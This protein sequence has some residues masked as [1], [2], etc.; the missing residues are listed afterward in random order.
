MFVFAQLNKA[1]L[2]KSRCLCLKIKGYEFHI[3]HTTFCVRGNVTIESL[4]LLTVDEFRLEIH[5]F[6]RWDLVIVRIILLNLV[7]LLV[8]YCCMMSLYSEH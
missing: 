2:L 6:S 8:I 4:F 3:S 1:L 5:L 7:M